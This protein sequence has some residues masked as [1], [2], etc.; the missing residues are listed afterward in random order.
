MKI[1]AMLMNIDVLDERMLN[2]RIIWKLYTG[3]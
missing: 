1:H 2:I 3:K